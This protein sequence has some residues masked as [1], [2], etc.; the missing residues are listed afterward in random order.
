MPILDL[1]CEKI[2]QLRNGAL[3]LSPTVHTRVTTL[4]G[5]D[6]LVAAFQIY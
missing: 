2:I 1:L 5:N 3:A 6:I 4:G